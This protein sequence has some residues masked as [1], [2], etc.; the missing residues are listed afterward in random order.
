MN[1]TQT[2]TWR[3]LEPLEPTCN[4]I[5][6]AMG[7]KG[8][9]DIE[10]PIVNNRIRELNDTMRWPDSLRL[11]LVESSSHHA[12]SDRVQ[13]SFG[14]LAPRIWPT[15]TDHGRYQTKWLVDAQ[16]DSLDGSH[17]VDLY[18]FIP[19]HREKSVSRLQI[20]HNFLIHLR[21]RKIF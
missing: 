19:A 2:H 13:A 14:R 12:F 7:L 15:A 17:T 6:K 10:V 3:H 11:P 21:L 9:F 18:H 16:V 1:I 20:Y 8:P 4:D 5:T